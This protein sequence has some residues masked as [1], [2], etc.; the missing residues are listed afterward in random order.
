MTGRLNPNPLWGTARQAPQRKKEH[1]EFK[2][3][4]RGPLGTQI[5]IRGESRMITHPSHV[6]NRFHGCSWLL[7]DLIKTRSTRWMRMG[8][9]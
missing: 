9:R 8:K 4:V 2:R 6:V 3:L 1:A 7:C 5:P